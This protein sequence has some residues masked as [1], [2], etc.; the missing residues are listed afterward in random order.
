MDTSHKVKVSPKVKVTLRDSPQPQGGLQ[1]WY[2]TPCAPAHTLLCS[3]TVLLT[4]RLRGKAGSLWWI[5][6]AGSSLQGP[7]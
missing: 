4:P 6:G 5:L 3:H 2:S 7:P 1:G